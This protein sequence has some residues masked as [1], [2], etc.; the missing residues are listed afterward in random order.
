M[1]DRVVSLGGGPIPDGN[2]AV[3]EVVELFEEL[4]ER[5]RSGDIVGV[6]G[7]LAHFDGTTSGFRS[8]AQGRGLIGCLSILVVTA[9]LEDG[10]E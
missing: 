3:P 2:E 9:S 5:A 4:L 7:G 8:G 1:S 10:N 6:C